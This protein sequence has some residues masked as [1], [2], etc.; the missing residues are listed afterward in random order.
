MLHV[1]LY[2]LLYMH[3]VCTSESSSTKHYLEGYPSMHLKGLEDVQCALAI[4]STNNECKQKID[5]SV[6]A[7]IDN[8]ACIFAIAYVHDKHR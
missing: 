3:M 5:H 1:Y 2:L 8:I 7:S 4:V 6:Q